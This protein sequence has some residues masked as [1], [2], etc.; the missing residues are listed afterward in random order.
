AG[1]LA[2][3]ARR[4]GEAPAGGPPPR[5]GWSVVADPAGGPG[6]RVPPGGARRGGAPAAQDHFVPGLGA[7]AGGAGTRAAGRARAV[8]VAAG[9]GEGVGTTL[10]RVR[11]HLR[12]LPR[13]GIGYGLFRYLRDDDA[14][15]PLR[16][17][18]RPAIGF[19]YLGQLDQ[20][21]PAT[22]LFAPAAEP[23]GAPVS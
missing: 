13:H 12:A 2:R 8:V 10:R 11:E 15:A 23:A 3:T 14:V 16:R 20:I 17:A 1:R 21:L 6:D 7:R 4:R 18:V 5:H 22:S 19:N 9:P